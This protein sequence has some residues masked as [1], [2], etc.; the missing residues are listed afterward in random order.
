[1]ASAVHYVHPDKPP[2]LWVNE[3][4]V[5]T[6]HHRR[7]VATSLLRALFDRGRALGCAEAW[8]LT[9]DDNGPARR[10]H[11]GVGGTEAAER[12]VCVTFR[13]AR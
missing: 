9:D 10:L 3:V 1:M 2:E 6:M 12:P 4:G 11:A 8:V 7:G 13:L 5:A